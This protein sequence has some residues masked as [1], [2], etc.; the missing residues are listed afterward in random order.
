MKPATYLAAW[1]AICATAVALYM[2]RINP[3][4]I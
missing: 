4:F 1:I 2:V 3:P